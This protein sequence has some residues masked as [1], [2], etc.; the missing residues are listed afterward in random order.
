MMNNLKIDKNDKGGVDV[1]LN[2]QKINSVIS[3]TVEENSDIKTATLK[4]ALS[5]IEIESW[6]RIYGFA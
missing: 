2:G 3:Y 1:F 5:K 4:F 6:L